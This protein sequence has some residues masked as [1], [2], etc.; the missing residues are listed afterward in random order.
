MIA[1]GNEGR[2]PHRDPGGEITWIARNF[3][4]VER[5]TIEVTC[6]DAVWRK[7]ER[8]RSYTESTFRGELIQCSNPNCRK[9]AGDVATIFR[10]MV[11]ERTEHRVATQA[12][13][14]YEGSGRARSRRCHHQFS[15]TISIKYY[16]A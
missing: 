15:F 3:P 6:A 14:G 2:L 1:D 4:E 12:C 11:R 5:A 10:E 16:A 9:G 7:N 8:S 13:W